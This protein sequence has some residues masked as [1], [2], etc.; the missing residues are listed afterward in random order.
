MDWLR[1]KL[2]FISESIVLFE[3]YNEEL[4]RSKGAIG[5]ILNVSELGFEI[6]VHRT[7]G[8]NY[9]PEEYPVFTLLWADIEGYQLQV[10]NEP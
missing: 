6:E 1:E 10:I 8:H 4:D 9:H 5:R 7:G 2:V 3:K